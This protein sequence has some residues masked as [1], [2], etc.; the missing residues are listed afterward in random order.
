[1]DQINVKGYNVALGVAL[2]KGYLKDV[3][4]HYITM[5]NNAYNKRE[6]LNRSMQGDK[7]AHEKFLKLQSEY[8]NENLN[9]L[10]KNASEVFNKCVEKDGKLIQLTDPVFLDPTDSKLGR[11]HFFAPRKNL[12]GTYYSTF[13][14]NLCVIWFMSFTLMVTLY[15]DVF[16][17]VLDLFGNINFFRKKRA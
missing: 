5:N 16:K 10:V 1:M 11:A 15:F 9:N 7:V 14:F 13:C 4:D 6:E 8:D 2:R 17:K 3:K 12:F